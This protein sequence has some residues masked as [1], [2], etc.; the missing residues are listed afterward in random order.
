VRRPKP[1]RLR[2]LTRSAARACSPKASPFSSSCA[3]V[4][5]LVATH[6]SL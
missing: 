4:L 1:F 6:F 2:R 3:F 5:V